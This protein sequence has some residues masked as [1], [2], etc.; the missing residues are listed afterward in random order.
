VKRRDFISAAAAAA[1]AASLSLRSG[2]ADQKAYTR[3][4]DAMPADAPS[5]PAS[6]IPRVSHPRHDARGMLYRQLGSTGEEVSVIG[7]GGSHLGRPLASE[8][9][10][11]RRVAGQAFGSMN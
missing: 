3:K 8:N 10:S 7:L 11:G 9:S 4:G 6:H 2:A 5:K 1:T